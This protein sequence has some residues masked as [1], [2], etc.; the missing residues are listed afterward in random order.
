MSRGV[1]DHGGAKAPAPLDRAQATVRSQRPLQ[2]DTTWTPGVRSPLPSPFTPAAAVV[3]E[4]KSRQSLWPSQWPET[5]Q[6]A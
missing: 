4:A 5:L 1:P 2:L 3:A 6:E